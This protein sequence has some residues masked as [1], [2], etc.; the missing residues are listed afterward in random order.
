M[1]IIIIL[2]TENTYQNKGSFETLSSGLELYRVGSDE[3]GKA[4]IIAPDI[5][6]YNS[7]RTRAIADL[8][9][10]QGQQSS[11]SIIIVMIIIIITSIIVIQVISLLFRSF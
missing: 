2:Y 4:I 7:G 6:G 11:I 9:A 1:I 5:W 10:D 3:S 8:F